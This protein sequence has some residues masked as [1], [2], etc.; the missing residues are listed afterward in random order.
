MRGA[1]RWL[2]AGL[3]VLL[4]LGASLFAARAR[5]QV[6]AER[7]KPAVTHDGWVTAEGADTRHLDDP[8]ELG[9][10]INY[11]RNSLVAVDADGNVTQQFVAGR[12]GLDLIGSLSLAR[13][14][15]I[16]LGLPVYLLQQGDT[17][18]S[19]A[20]LGDLRVVPKLQLLDDR[21]SI[22]LAL[23]AEVR[24]PTHTG[25]FSGSNRGVQVLPKVIVDHRF[26]GGL[27]VGGNVGAAF[28]EDSDFFNVVVGDEL[29]YALAVGYRFGG[30]DGKTELGA[31]L[32]GG[33]GLAELDAEEA[34]LELL[35]FL[36]HNPDDEW[37]LIGGPGLGII[38]GYGVPTFRVFFGVRYTPTSH[39]SD[40]D[41]IADAEDE[42][43]NYAE[44]RDGIEDDDGCPEEDPDS[45]RDGV[46]DV[47]DE[48]PE[49]KETING[50]DDEDGCPD[51]GDARVV[52]EEGRFKILDTV[53]F[54]TG[55]AKLKPESHS[56]L[57]QVALTMKANPDV[58]KIRIE[59]HTDDTGP[60]EVN[61][62]LS[63]Q[64]AESVKRYLV[65][66]GVSPQRLSAQGYGPD[67][68][69]EDGT[70]DEARARNRR[71]EFVV[72]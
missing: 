17:E 18:P 6:D 71:V 41:G 66:K 13:S 14:F 39:D 43:P 44:D 37:E 4:A 57:D 10:F 23:A 15:S 51:S 53:K 27:R 42:C 3:V 36:R 55:S 12:M 49:A 20:G 24:A 19:F 59:G 54:E 62:R 1:E 34:P 56:L 16:G 67:K 25:D 32:N 70:D 22:G 48:C 50:V 46:P 7:F 29:T 69:L 11:Q 9:A 38:E 33:M 40:H 8:W 31:E 58:K 72:E 28:R 61:M 64:R 60:R 30:H 26:R 47:D 5:A 63:E 21:D 65:D 45:D 68:P 2:R 52:Y 35:A